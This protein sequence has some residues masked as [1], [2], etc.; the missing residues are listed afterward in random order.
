M[1]KIDG[2]QKRLGD[3]VDE[4][5]MMLLAMM[6]VVLCCIFFVIYSLHKVKM[7]QAKVSE[8]LDRIADAIGENST[9]IN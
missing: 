4:K 9:K 1:M 3:Q 8:R 5:I 6:A 7:S 2:Y